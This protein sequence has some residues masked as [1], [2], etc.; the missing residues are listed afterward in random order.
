MSVSFSEKAKQII[1]LIAPTLGTALG[2]PLGGAA[3]AAVAA[4]L[5]GYAKAAEAAILSQDPA[6][7][8]ALKKADQEFAVQMKTLEVDEDRLGYQDVASARD[9]AKT[10]LRPQIWLSVL[11][12]GGYFGL[13]ISV[14]LGAIKLDSQAAQIYPVLIG[15]L[16]AGV[17]Q[18]LGFFFGSSSGSQAKSTML[19]N[20]K[21]AS[22]P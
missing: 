3:G 12:I 22:A 10:D 7:L 14:G 16:A 20:S 17:P 9:L 1:K 5:G 8:L 18:I 6:T 2:G 19:Y 15:V 21:P 11:F 13:L 4:A